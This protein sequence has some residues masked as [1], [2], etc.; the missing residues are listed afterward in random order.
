MAEGEGESRT[1]RGVKTSAILFAALASAGL[2]AAA[3]AQATNAQQQPGTI[4]T[5]RA[6]V[7][8]MQIDRTLDPMFQQLMPL[9]VANVEHAMADATDTP[10]ALKTRLKNG[11]GRAQVGTIIAE[12]FTAAFRHLYPDVGEAAAEQYS[13]LFSEPELAAILAFCASPAGAKLLALL[14]ELQKTMAEQGRALGR[15]AGIAAIPKI[16]ARLTAL[17]APSA[18]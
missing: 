7:A 4:K 5:G 14:P 12:E 18:K 3:Q 17:D 11:S 6:I 2:P 9:M 16:Q 8:R 13:K 1:G 15:D 10:A